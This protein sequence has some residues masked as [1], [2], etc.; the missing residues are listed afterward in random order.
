MYIYLT[1]TANRLFL[2]F[3]TKFSSLPFL[4]SIPYSSDTIAKHSP[5]KVSEDDDLDLALYYL[6]TLYNVLRWAPDAIWGVL[7]TKALSVEGTSVRIAD[8]GKS[9]THLPHGVS[10]LTVFQPAPKGK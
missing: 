6:R 8:L 5:T 3:I 2:S 4:E 9:H 10:L 7:A 1:L